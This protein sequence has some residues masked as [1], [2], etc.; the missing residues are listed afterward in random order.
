MRASMLQSLQRHLSISQLQHLSGHPIL[1]LPFEAL[2]PKHL[3]GPLFGAA[4]FLSGA[5]SVIGRAACYDLHSA[6]S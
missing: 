1:I 6:P 3:M 4:L 2:S 5:D